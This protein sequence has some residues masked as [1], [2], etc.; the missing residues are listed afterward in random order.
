MPDLITVATANKSIY[1]WLCGR[2]FIAFGMLYLFASKPKTFQA[3]SFKYITLI[4]AL[5]MFIVIL[6]VGLF[7]LDY[8]PALFIEGIG[9]TK[10]KIYFELF[11]I[12][13]LAIAL[14]LFYLRNEVIKRHYDIHNLYMAMVIMIMSES[15][16]MI[17]TS[18]SDVYNFL[19]HIYKVISYFFFYRA[20]FQESIHRPYFELDKKNHELKAAKMAADSANMAKGQFLANMSHE[21]RTPMNAIIGLTGLIA[22]TNLTTEQK[23]YVE[24]LDQS[25]NHLLG[26]IDDI[27]ELS[28]I[29]AGAME[30]RH[31][32]FDLVGT[33]KKL[34]QMLSV[35]AQKKNIHLNLKTSNDL[36]KIV[37]GDQ[38]KFNR[39]LINLVS[40]A[41]KFTEQGHIT[42]TC[43][44]KEIKNNT[45]T[46]QFDITDT[47][48][49]IP[50][51]QIKN[52]FT[53]FSQIDFSNTRKYGGSGLGLA[54]TKKLVEAM[55]GTIWVESQVNRGSTFSFSIKL[56]VKA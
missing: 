47:G 19:G 7:K 39:I 16:F 1:F 35:S 41:I 44:T 34:E 54:I 40:N 2:V 43:I 20:L 56:E 31:Q 12:V 26:V 6:Y 13:I 42:I 29:E 28:K 30:L 33:I 25:G 17:F 3:H 45:A 9:L 38:N 23:Q 24:L 48:I 18:H 51:D 8:I 32:E 46:I 52:L 55:N 53:N 14:A 27:L 36:P 10:F 5:I 22:E 50:Q 11:V 49:G 4:I 15:F 21:I 37:I